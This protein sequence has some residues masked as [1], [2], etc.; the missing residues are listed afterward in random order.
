MHMLAGQLW[1]TCATQ[2][3]KERLKFT[4][5]TNGCRRSSLAGSV[6]RNLSASLHQHQ[7]PRCATKAS[8][9][10]TWA[11]VAHVASPAS[12]ATASDAF[13]PMA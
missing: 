1:P 8:R 4:F 7:V 5:S 9:R 13:V 10:R 6:S 11:P 3:W 12:R 2:R